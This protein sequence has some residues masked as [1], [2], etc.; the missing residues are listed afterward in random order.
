M[1]YVFTSKCLLCPLCRT[2]VGPEVLGLMEEVH[3]V[4]DDFFMVCEG[5][6]KN[7]I[8]EILASTKESG[9]GYLFD[10]NSGLGKASL[11]KAILAGSFGAVVPSLSIS[12]S[13]ADYERV[14]TDIFEANEDLLEYTWAVGPILSKPADDEG[15]ERTLRRF[16]SAVVR[17]AANFNINFFLNLLK[18][19]L[20]EGV[21]IANRPWAIKIFHGMA[22]LK[23]NLTVSNEEIED[24]QAI[25][26]DACK[27]FISRGVPVD[28]TSGLGCTALMLA[29]GAGNYALVEA[30]I[31]RGA[32]QER[33]TEFGSP[34][35]HWVPYWTPK[36]MDI[37]KLLIK[38][39]ADVNASDVSGGTAL[40]QSIMYGSIEMVQF[41]VDNGAR[42]DVGGEAEALYYAVQNGRCENVKF[43]LQHGVSPN[44]ADR[45]GYTALM[46]ASKSGLLDLAKTLM[47]ADAD[48]NV[49]GKDGATALS[50]AKQSGCEELVAVLIAHGARLSL[51][52]R[53]FT[54]CYS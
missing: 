39:G 34:A 14:L 44:H 4:T 20:P 13:E 11:V 15:L 26:L 47:A 52:H 28:A 53:L 40:C 8:E 23:E 25:F 29:V 3:R 33:K 43:L 5:G 41:L 45:E 36:S 51:T 54:C 9:M 12:K 37:V 10:M 30:L 21:S 49:V 46:Y 32:D 16:K 38:K 27:L 1:Q 24:A 19:I 2:E 17:D 31:D 50:L 6:D 35:L 22:E 7:K 42:L 18:L 48:V